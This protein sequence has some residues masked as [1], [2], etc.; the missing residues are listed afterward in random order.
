MHK[1]L[2]DGMVVLRYLGFACTFSLSEGEDIAMECFFCQDDIVN[3]QIDLF[4]T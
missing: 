2:V 3:M 4:C 1:L